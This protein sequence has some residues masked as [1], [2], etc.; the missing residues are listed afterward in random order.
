MER[1][2]EEGW[3]IIVAGEWGLSWEAK[4]LLGMI[5]RAGLVAS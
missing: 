1:V 5:E 2:E 4:D 3:Q